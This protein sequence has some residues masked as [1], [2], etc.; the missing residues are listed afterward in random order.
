VTKKTKSNSRAKRGQPVLGVDVDTLLDA[1]RA[2]RKNAYAPYSNYRVG[3]AL[4]CGSGR[5]YSGCNVENASY[6]LCLC[7]ER[8]AVAQ[9]VANGEQELLAVA[10][11]G[12]GPE[13]VP[14]CGMCRQTLAELMKPDAPVICENERGKRSTFTVSELLPHAF[15][16]RFL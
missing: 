2:V 12:Q 15:S 14:P 9:A 7:A 1:A 13:P 10:I 6:G 5:V 11:S 8:S 16:K 4:L 3:A